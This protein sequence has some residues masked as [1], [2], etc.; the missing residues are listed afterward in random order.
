MF[1]ARLQEDSKFCSLNVMFFREDGADLLLKKIP[2][3]APYRRA[4]SGNFMQYLIFEKGTPY[5]M[6]WRITFSQSALFMIFGTG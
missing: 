6:I 5:S 4:V 1:R 2:P 3:T